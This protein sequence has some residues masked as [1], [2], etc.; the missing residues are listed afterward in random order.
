[1]DFHDEAELLSYEELLSRV[2]NVYETWAR[3]SEERTNETRRT[4]TGGP[5]PLGF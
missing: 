2:R 4:G 1:L 3:V 5:T